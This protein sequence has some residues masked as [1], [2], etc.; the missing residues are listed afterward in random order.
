MHLSVQECQGLLG[1]VTRVVIE[2]GPAD[3]QTYTHNGT[4]A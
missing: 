3:G 1:A 2:T 4:S